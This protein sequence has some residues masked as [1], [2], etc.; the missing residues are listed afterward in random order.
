MF[1]QDTIIA[2][3]TGVG[4]SAICLFRLSGINS[5]E[6]VYQNQLNIEIG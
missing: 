2:K 6:M 3:A 1:N 4:S 5:I